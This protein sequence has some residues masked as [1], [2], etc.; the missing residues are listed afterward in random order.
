MNNMVVSMVFL[1]A[2]AVGIGIMVIDVQIAKEKRKMLNEENE[3]II[4]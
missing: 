2:L 3:E 4:S 1:L